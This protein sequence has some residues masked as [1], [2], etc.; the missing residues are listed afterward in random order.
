ME[1]CVKAPEQLTERLLWI[2]RD[3]MPSNRGFTPA[4]HPRSPTGENTAQAAPEKDPA[5]TAGQ[6]STNASPTGQGALR[7][8]AAVG[9]KRYPK[10]KKRF[11]QKDS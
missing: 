9:Y 4:V 1:V 5:L 11:V 8:A 3:D 6:C 2:V 7:K 10:R